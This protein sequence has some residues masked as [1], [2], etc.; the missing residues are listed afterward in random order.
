M[1]YFAPLAA[2]VVGEIFARAT[3]RRRRSSSFDL[4]RAADAR[5]KGGVSQELAAMALDHI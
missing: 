2:S 4:A 5:N 3:A 1:R